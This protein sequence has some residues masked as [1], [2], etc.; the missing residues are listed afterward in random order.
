MSY[1]EENTDTVKKTIYAM[2][3]KNALDYSGTVNPKAII[4]KVLSEIPE[5]KKEVKEV[6]PLIQETAARV[7]EMSP[8]E[9]AQEV[10]RFNDLFEVKEKQTKGEELK[11]LPEATDGNVVMRIAPSPSGP[12]HIG[13]AYVI[14][15]NYEYT[16]QYNG[17]FIVRVEDTNPE[18]VY[19]PAYE[20]IKN[21]TDWLSDNNVAAFVIQSDRIDQYYTYAEKLFHSGHLYVCTC[22]GE[23]FRTLLNNKQACP[24]RSLSVEE[25]LLRWQKMLDPNGYK[26]GEAVVRFK[27]DIE[28][29]NPA[30]R[31]FPLLRINEAPHP[32][33]GN[34]YRVWPLMN[35]SVALDDMLLGVTHTLRGKDHADNAKRQEMIHH[36]L[37]CATPYAISVGRINFKG[38][39]LSTTKTMA[40]IKEG[41]YSGF[42]DIRLP[43]LVA[44]RKRGFC[45]EAFRKYAK[46]VGVTR[47][48]KTVE[49]DDYF[50]T[51]ESLNR[52][53][54]DSTTDRYFFVWDPVRIDVENV[55]E[56]EITLDLHPE[57]KKGG[58]TFVLSDGSFYLAKDDVDSIKPEETVRLMDCLNFIKKGDDA[59]G[60]NYVYE[61]NDYDFFRK[62]GNQIIHFLPAQEH[63]VNV[64][65]VMPDG[66]L[67]SGY[68]EQ[69]I[70]NVSVGDV[71]Q[72]ERFGFCRLNDIR[73]TEDTKQ[74]VYVFWYAHK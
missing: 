47:T 56:S 72:F 67:R 64:E 61:N 6:M 12:L 39:E 33:V 3:L 38:F 68:G 51:L 26:Q 53:A 43:F 11:P 44:L 29:S 25:Q 57:H 22:D 42:D 62:T 52:D 55:P 70:E 2:C 66:S 27:S 4:G 16:R 50:K 21:D 1:V 60:Y 18:N 10:E 5:L 73:Y 40:K 32:R 71:V 36:A 45:A 69:G 30:M 37:G 31:D 17:K 15:L 24:C 8:E 14:S 23:E 74:K 46:L 59:H 49:I 9:Q 41:V 54:I 48:D 58:R 28:H 65:V 35:L 13:H 19:Q 7:N 63:L 34:R 20:L